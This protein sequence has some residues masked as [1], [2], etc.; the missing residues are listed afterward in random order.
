MIVYWIHFIIQF[1]IL[2]AEFLK[3]FVKEIIVAELVNV[4]VA[5]SLVT[6]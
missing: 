4:N 3:Y 2:L 6:F 5:L 1:F